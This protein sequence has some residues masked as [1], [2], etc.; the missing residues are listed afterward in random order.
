MSTPH[1]QRSL[2]IPRQIYWQKRTSTSKRRTVHWLQ[3]VHSRLYQG[4]L[5]QARCHW[6]YP[7]KYPLYVTSFSIWTSL[8]RTQPSRSLQTKKKSSSLQILSLSM[9]SL[10]ISLENMRRAVSSC[11][12]LQK[13]MRNSITSV[14]ND[15]GSPISQHS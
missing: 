9:D 13:M 3:M 7:E 8:T 4:Y 15:I 12:L 6:I 2:P 14:L 1:P 10:S 11:M 5:D